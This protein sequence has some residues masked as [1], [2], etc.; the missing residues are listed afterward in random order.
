MIPYSN[1]QANQQQ[2]AF[3]PGLWSQQIGAV[4]QNQPALATR[5]PRTPEQ[6]REDYENA[7]QVA[8]RD[9]TMYTWM[10]M[11]ALV[12][13]AGLAKLVMYL[14]TFDKGRTLVCFVGGVVVTF[15][16][17]RVIYGWILKRQLD[18][19]WAVKLMVE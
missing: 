1:P 11:V 6:I 14:W 10:T 19:E 12:L 16:T 7:K 2:G 17:L 9:A 4:L 15:V 13:L 18:N 5:A 3:V 8:K